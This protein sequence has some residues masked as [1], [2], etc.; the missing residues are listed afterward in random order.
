M[1]GWESAQF[2]CVSPL[3]T[4]IVWDVLWR[5][6][7]MKRIL[8]LAL[9]GACAGGAAQVRNEAKGPQV[10]GRAFRMRVQA[11]GLPWSRT[12]KSEPQILEVSAEALRIVSESGGDGVILRFDRQ[13][14]YTLDGAAKKFKEEPMSA[15]A[16]MSAKRAADREKKRKKILEKARSDEEADEFLQK[17][18]LRRDGKTILAV[19]ETRSTKEIAGHSCKLYE[20]KE[21][22]RV[23]LSVWAAEKLQRPGG[24]YRLFGETG[25][26]SEEMAREVRSIPGF[27][28]GLDLRMDFS[29]AL[30]HITITALSLEEVDGG[31]LDFDV[32]QGFELSR[33][34]DPGDSH[35][36]RTCGSPVEPST[37]WTLRVPG[38]KESRLY[39]KEE[40]KKL[41]KLKIKEERM[42]G[43]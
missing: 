17:L 38:E 11:E 12:S 7:P 37:P 1:H 4:V 36:C 6:V 28:L 34:D 20:V 42:R 5:R 43:K 9:L 33:K 10:E 3:F 40:C 27:P 23:V 18:G 26:F 8:W 29:L 22:G 13:R 32:P 24:L 25:I 30:I 2:S 16:D 35:A 39:D 31:S 15:L 21:N 14:T 41:D 19:E